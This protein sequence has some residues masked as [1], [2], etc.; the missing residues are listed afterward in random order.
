MLKACKDGIAR[1]QAPAA[2]WLQGLALQHN[3]QLPGCST[4]A[5]RVLRLLFIKGGSVEFAHCLL[6]PRDLWVRC[7]QV[8]AHTWLCRP[9]QVVQKVC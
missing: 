7:R 2:N 6:E 5:P 1:V 4:K 3:M 8:P 9:S